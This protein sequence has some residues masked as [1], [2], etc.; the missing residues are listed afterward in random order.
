MKLIVL[1]FSFFLQAPKDLCGVLKQGYPLGVLNCTF[2]HMV[3]KD[4]TKIPYFSYPMPLSIE[5]RMENSSLFALFFDAYTSALPRQDGGRVR[6]YP[7][8]NLIYGKD[9]KEIQSFLVLVPFLNKKVPFNKNNNASK[10]LYQVGQELE[11]L[12]EKNPQLKEYLTHGGTFN[13]RVIAKTNR[14]SAHSYGI[15]IDLGVQKSRYWQWDKKFISPFQALD[16]P[17]EIINI[18]EKHGFIWGGYW[19]HYDS[20]HFEYRPE[21]L[22]LKK[23]KRISHET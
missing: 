14:L 2:T 17:Q 23:I 1:L 16:Y 5:E 3:L 20:M 11:K 22:L 10:A 7:L 12:L 9:K 21:Y 15:A 6:L 8:L 13:Y 18:F 19:K 4:N